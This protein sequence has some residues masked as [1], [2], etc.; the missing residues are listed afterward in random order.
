MLVGDIKCHHH[1]GKQFDNFLT[2]H[3][4]TPCKA[5]I[6]FLSFVTHTHTHTHTGPQSIWIFVT[7]SLNISK[8]WEQFQHP[9]EGEWNPQE[10]KGMMPS[11]Q[12]SLPKC[13]TCMYCFLK[14][15]TYSTG[16]Q[17][18]GPQGFWMQGSRVD[19]TENDSRRGS[20]WW[21]CP[22][23]LQWWSWD[24]H[25]CCMYTTNVILYSGYMKVTTDVC[26]GGG[27]ANGWRAH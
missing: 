10:Y 3:T 1:S 2:I 19:V 22:F 4:H 26:V 24:L 25:M 8:I 15:K 5:E 23:W 12:K 9:S 6:I 7:L 27:G 16:G 11:E 17:M 21:N 14:Q 13:H 20:W 18:S